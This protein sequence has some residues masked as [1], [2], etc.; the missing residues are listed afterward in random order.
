M[1]FDDG[2]RPYGRMPTRFGE[3]L[4]CMQCAVSTKPTFFTF[5]HGFFLDG[6]SEKQL[7]DTLVSLGGTY[8]RQNNRVLCPWCHSHDNPTFHDGHF[9]LWRSVQLPVQDF[10]R[11]WA[12]VETADWIPVSAAAGEEFMLHEAAE[13]LRVGPHEQWM[14][15]R[16]GQDKGRPPLAPPRMPALPLGPAVIGAIPAPPPPPGLAAVQAQMADLQRALDAQQEEIRILQARTT[17]SQ[18]AADRALR[19]GLEMEEIVA[20]WDNWHRTGQWR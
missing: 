17:N 16:K 13:R 11:F 5:L 19:I 18:E 3:V 15:E 14:L 7:R 4:I 9:R 20:R 8:S 6:F 1:D 2:W 10:Y 12:L